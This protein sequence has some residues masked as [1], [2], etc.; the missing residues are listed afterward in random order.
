MTTNGFRLFSLSVKKNGRGEEQPLEVGPKSEPEHIRDYIYNLAA[1]KVGL[2]IHGMPIPDTQDP[3]DDDDDDSGATSSYTYSKPVMVIKS[4][5]H[6][7]DHVVLEFVYGR[8]T[9]HEEAGYS[10]HRPS[11]PFSIGDRKSVRKFR[12]AFIFPN[13]GEGG[14]LAIEDFGRTCPHK[15]LERWLKAWARENAKE[16]AAEHVASTGKKK[17]FDWWTA[18]Q[19]PLKDSARLTAMMR[20]GQSTQIV[21]TKKGG[22]NQRTPGSQPLK[23]EMGLADSR[24]LARTRALIDGW[25]GDDDDERT[26]QKKQKKAG[27]DLAAIV[28]DRYAGFDSEDY[29]DAWVY[30]KDGDKKKK[31][32]PSRWADVFIYSVSSGVERPSEARFYGKIRD[33]I[34]PLEKSLELKID[35]SGW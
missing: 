33:T 28:A 17:K 11:A 29:D 31:I 21:L 26:L 12:A 34:E 20:N 5:S 27:K 8:R 24:A 22:S 10:E 16:A 14:V 7:G 6:R 2:E 3:D 13:S 35:W 32:S 15:M 19:T 4:V 23:V 9:G 18:R 25:F 1:P 30:V